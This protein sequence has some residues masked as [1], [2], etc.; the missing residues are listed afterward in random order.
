VSCVPYTSSKEVA[1]GWLNEG[2]TVFARTTGGQGGSGITIV[3]PGDSLPDKPLYTQYVK[4]RKE[5]RVHVY[6]GKAIDVQEKRK[7]NGG[8]SSPIRSH[9]NGY[10]FCHN[11]VSEPEGLRSLGAAAISAVGLPLGAVDIIYNEHQGKLFVLEAN[12]APGLCL[13]TAEKYANA[14]QG[15]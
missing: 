2:K 14:I 5:F 4:K 6:D 7:R 8:E 11:D 10:V 12:S 1:Q 13:T 15:Q 3:R 9:G